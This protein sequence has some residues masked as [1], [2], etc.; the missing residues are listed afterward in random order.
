MTWGVKTQHGQREAKVTEAVAALGASV[1]LSNRNPTQTGTNCMLTAIPVTLVYFLG[2]ISPGWRKHRDPFIRCLS[3]GNRHNF[4][5]KGKMT[6]LKTN[7]GMH[8]S[9]ISKCK[10]E[11]EIPINLSNKYK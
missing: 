9:H 1:T 2:K 8:V 10:R 5:E 6:D 7:M 11:F 4:P 3:C